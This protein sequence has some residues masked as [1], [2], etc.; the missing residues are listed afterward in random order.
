ME[1]RIGELVVESDS[2][3]PV[4]PVLSQFVEKIKQACESPD[5]PK[6][7]QSLDEILGVSHSAEK[8]RTRSAAKEIVSMENNEAISNSSSPIENEKAQRKIES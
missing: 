7:E 5:S 4:Q 2:D 3:S 8:P 6:I 1:K